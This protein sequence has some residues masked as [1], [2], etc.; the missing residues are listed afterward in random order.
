M[1]SFINNDKMFPKKEMLNTKVRLEFDS[2]LAY[3]LIE[4]GKDTAKWLACQF[5]RQFKAL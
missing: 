5:Y 4:F 3:N 1:E 2:N